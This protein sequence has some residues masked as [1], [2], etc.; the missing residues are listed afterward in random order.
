[1]CEQKQTITKEQLMAHAIEAK[2]FSYSPYS[3]FPVGSA[4]L[5]ADGRVI[6]GANIENASF[7]AT[8][9]AERSAIFAGASM[10][11]RK[12][13]IVAIAVN[14]NTHDF[15]PPCNIC[16]QVMVEFCD[17]N[18]PVYLSNAN[19]D[20]LELTLKELTPYSFTTLEM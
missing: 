13:D 14:G 19:G 18:T 17:E 11:Y 8:N 2:Q 7:G 4:V 6:K 20:I 16:R 12:G 15:L 1:M 5:Y 3:H 9:C 10:G